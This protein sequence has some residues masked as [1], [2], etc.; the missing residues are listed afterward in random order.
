MKPNDQALI[1]DLASQPARF[2]YRLEP[3]QAWFELLR[4]A[5]EATRTSL[6]RSHGQHALPTAV[7]CWKG[8]QLDKK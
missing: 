1:S 5:A 2:E 3:V 6:E 7:E 4:E 8:S